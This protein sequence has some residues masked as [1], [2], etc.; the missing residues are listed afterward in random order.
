MTHLTPVA[1]L[2]AVRIQIDPDFSSNVTLE[3]PAT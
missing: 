2:T 1:R 3:Q